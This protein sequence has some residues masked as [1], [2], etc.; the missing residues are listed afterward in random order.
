MRCEKDRVVFWVDVV[1]SPR[2]VGSCALVAYPADGGVVSDPFG[3]LLVVARV[4]GSS[5]FGVLL[6]P[7]GLAG[8]A[9]SLVWCESMTVKTWALDGHGGW[10]GWAG[11]TRAHRA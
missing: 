2:V 7:G 1:G 3:A 10:G 11:V 5:A 8:V 9:S 4:F 6:V